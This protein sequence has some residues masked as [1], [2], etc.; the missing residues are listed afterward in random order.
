[1]ET[2]VVTAF[3][4]FLVKILN[5]SAEVVVK[6]KGLPDIMNYMMQICVNVREGELT[7]KV[8]TFF[9]TLIACVNNKISDQGKLI[10]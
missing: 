4:Q 1:V 6:S 5:I 3:S 7:E 8:V 9:L 2:D 10:V